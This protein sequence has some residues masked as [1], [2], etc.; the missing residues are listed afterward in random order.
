MGSIGEVSYCGLYCP[1]CGVCCRLPKQASALLETMK[2]GDWDDFG[3]GIEGFTPFWKFL[4]GLA[5]MSAPKRCR[6]GTCG[7]P[8]CGMR[9][10]SKNKS[11]ET[12]PQCTEYPCEKIQK[13]S[14]SEPTLI[15]DGERLKE[16]G[17]EKWVEE[18]EARRRK[19]FSYDDIRCGKGTIP[20]S[21]T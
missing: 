21:D 3:H 2:T 8:N 6:N 18:Q 19:D 11:I 4:H 10:C 9:E 16:V 5:D 1:N 13:F 17:L 7:A 12:C 14:K 20:E 15:F